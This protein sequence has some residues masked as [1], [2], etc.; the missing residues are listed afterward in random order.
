MKS[1]Q[2]ERALWALGFAG[3]L[4]VPLP[5]SG[6]DMRGQDVRHG[7]PV[8]IEWH[9]PG[10][11]PENVNWKRPG[12]G[13]TRDQSLTVESAPSERESGMSRGAG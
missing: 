6:P 13:P 10:K 12:S 8:G 11:A 9:W 5:R 2:W 7:A 3:L 1:V 4:A